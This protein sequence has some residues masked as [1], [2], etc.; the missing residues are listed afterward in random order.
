MNY[1][2]FICFSNDI[3]Y[4]K[5][6][7]EGS[8][9]HFIDPVGGE[10]VCTDSEKEDLVFAYKVVKHVR[11]N[12]IVIAKNKTTVGIGSGNTSRV[13]SVQFAII[14]AKRSFSGKRDN[15]LGAVMASDAFFPFSDSIKIAAKANIK[16][17]IQPG[18]SISD[19]KVIEETDKEKI[20]MV[21]TGK[22]CFSHL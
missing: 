1:F 5:S 7:L 10:K 12:A 13:D 17:I 4:S 22:R 11:S 16:A 19:N 2:N 15:L 14:K 8:N 18:G 6:I 21:F 20:S 3:E 9:I